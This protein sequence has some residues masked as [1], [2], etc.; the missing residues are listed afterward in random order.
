MKM[1]SEPYQELKS[2]FKDILSGAKRLKNYYTFFGLMLSVSALFLGVDSES[3]NLRY[4]QALLLLLSSLSLAVLIIYSFRSFFIEKHSEMYYAFTLVFIWIAG[5]FSARLSLYLFEEFSMEL[6]FYFRWLFIPVLA[7]FVNILFIYAIKLLRKWRENLDGQMLEW[8]FLVMLNWH[9][10]LAYIVSNKQFDQMFQKLIEPTFSNLY[11]L[12]YFVMMLLD[13]LFI[14]PK[15][16][17]INKKVWRTT[18]IILWIFLIIAPWLVRWL[19]K[20]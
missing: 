18:L 19:T 17:R 20:L 6:E 8:F 9:L 1:L 2:C 11:L 5:L 12:Y 13:E 15:I 7:V 14:Y 10:Y 16:K 3:V 4:V